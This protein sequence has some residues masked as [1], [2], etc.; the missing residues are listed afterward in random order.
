MRLAVG[1]ETRR[2]RRSTIMAQ[3]TRPLALVTG[4]STGIG[5]ELA[6]CC[7]Q[8][9]FDLA[10][11]ADEPQVKEAASGFRS[12]WPPVKTV[13]A[14]LATIEGV[15]KFISAANRMNRPVE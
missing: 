6:K 13:G 7:V 12:F 14:D 10:V 1:Q 8:K 15:D 4:A 11:C 9:G 5:Y 2:Y 3:D